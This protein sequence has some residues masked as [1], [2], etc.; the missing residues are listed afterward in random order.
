MPYSEFSDPTGSPPAKRSQTTARSPGRPSKL[1]PA[2]RDRFIAAL[3]EGVSFASAA[4]LAG[5][6][7]STFYR[8]VEEGGK[9]ASGEYREFLE[10]VRGAQAEA[11]EACLRIVRKAAEKD[12]RAAAW[13]LERRFRGRWANERDRFADL[14]GSEYFSPDAALQRQLDALVRPD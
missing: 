5:I 6:G 2:V 9:Q 11:E 3:K 4:N 1:T 10:A 8:W 13:I 14:V 7:Q 12:W